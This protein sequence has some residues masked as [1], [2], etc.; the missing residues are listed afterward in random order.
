MNLLERID[1]RLA[2]MRAR[3]DPNQFE[4]CVTSLLT[5]LYP[6]LVPIVGGTD[7]GLDAEMASSDLRLIGLTITSSRTLDGA[8]ASLRTSLASMRRHGLPVERVMAANLA[9]MNRRRRIGLQAIAREFDC[10]LVQVFD[11][12]F[13]ANQFRSHPDWR[14]R[15]LGIEGGAFSLSREP[16]GSWPVD[17]HLPT[18]GRDELLA[19][20][21]DS[22]KDAVLHGVPGS[23][24]SHVAALLPGALFLEDQPSAERLLDDLIAAH[25]AIVIVDDAGGRLEELDRVVYARRAENLGYR[26]VATCWP[27]QLDDVTDH[28][29]AGQAFEVDLL[30]REEMGK[31]LRSRG[32]TRLAVIARILELAQG[33]PAWALNLAD[34]LIRDGDWRSVWTGAAV[35]TQVLAYLRRSGASPVAIELLAA[36]AMLGLVS[37]DQVRRLGR[38]LEI[39]RVDLRQVLES[40]AVA[41]LLDVQRV[42]T[43]GPQSSSGSAGFE[44]RYKVEPEI[45][46]ASIAADT[47]FAGRAPAVSL[48]ELRDE[49]PEKA[50]HLLQTQI[51]C[52]LVGAN[53]PII[54]TRQE[55]GDALAMI[56]THDQDAELLRSYALLGRDQARS[57]MDLLVERARTSWAAMDSWSTQRAT[58]MLAERV[59]DLVKDADPRE[60]VLLLLGLLAELAEG[61]FPCRET[62]I[63]LVAEL[64]GART[65]DLPDATHLVRVAE[66]LAAMPE[67]PS[68]QRFLSARLVLT[69]E[70]LQ[71]TFDDNYMSPEVL[72][73]FIL[74]SFTW[75][76]HDL[77]A[78]FQAARPELDRVVRQLPDADLTMALAGLRKWASLAE[79]HALPFGG[80][81]SEEQ[82]EEAS[83]VAVEF[84]G[85]VAQAIRRPGVRAQFNSIMRPFGIHLD[86]PDTLFAAVTAD[87]DFHEDWREAARRSEQSINVAL[88]PYLQ[89]SPAE[90]MRWIAANQEDLELAR[91]QSG[92]I[93]RIM[94]RIADEPDATRWLTAALDAG[95]AAQCGTLIDAA[96]SQRDIEPATVTILLSDAVTRPV[97]LAAVLH[98]DV[99][100]ELARHVISRTVATDLACRDLAIDIRQAS[101]PT[102]ALLFTHHDPS[103]RGTAAALWAAGTAI[104]PTSDEIAPEVPGHW[105]DAVKNFAVPSVLEDYYQSEALK[106]IARYAPDIYADLLARHA[107]AS[108][109]HD[110]FEE[111][112][113]SVRELDP[114]ER[115]RLWSRVA[116][117]RSANE[118]FWALAAG[119]VEWIKSVVGDGVARIDPLRLL[120]S[121]RC[122]NGPGISF[123]DIA[124]V[125]MPLGVEPDGLLWLLDIGT[126]FGEDHQRYAASLDQCRALAASADEDLA[127]LGARGV[128]V[129]ERRLAQARRGAREA[130]IRGRLR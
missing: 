38:L 120:D 21:T 47:F 31:L 27:H 57:V 1:R 109:A 25:P 107:Q 24:K 84:A 4:D 80:E 35:R 113:D 2:D 72:N 71:P 70:I 65:G 129:Y 118:L 52:A 77:R 105:I 125:F 16:R 95:L 32:I 12:A 76:E 66:V 41:G 88:A 59:A 29:P 128:E 119:N 6:G 91:G 61:G 28:L 64:R 123:E 37:E 100:Q 108:A 99:D 36:I 11:R 56:E 67:T 87:R 63:A 54:P 101:E 43:W 9:D 14:R 121:W 111:W 98:H 96:V 85:I 116:D 78:L 42:R 48:H 126:H 15:I 62:V 46:A 92:S 90:I 94:W 60:P 103:F 110:D 33:R 124:R 34:L 104:H 8:R 44:D 89:Q 18:V 93:G 53:E 117:T 73:Q 26:V 114:D 68:D 112:T 22:D 79:S 50:A 30:T 10:E 19:E 23:G 82:A 83:R 75:R 5:P 115:R 86:E 3:I 45:V 17:R 97:L 106:A 127:R 49:F 7:H 58:K 74:R 102:L 122:Q 39:P 51:H 40:V 13:F 20:L 55:F 81:P 69:L 130:A